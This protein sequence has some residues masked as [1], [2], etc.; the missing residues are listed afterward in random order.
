MN[1]ENKSNSVITKLL[2]DTSK[3]LVSWSL[4]QPPNSL[5]IGTERVI[6][7]YL[8][9]L[10]KEKILGLYELR[11]K[12]FYDEHDYY[13]S[14]TIGFC[15][16]D[17]DDTVIWE[18]PDYTPALNDLFNAARIQASGINDILNDLLSD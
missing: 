4:R 15:I 10:Y 1:I 18:L 14:S 3:G 16:V 7:L 11:T 6:P 17:T 9:A 13:W 12:S 2:R 5:L 8:E